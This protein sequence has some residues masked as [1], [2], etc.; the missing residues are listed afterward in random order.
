[1]L[2]GGKGNSWVSFFL[3]AP[4][5]TY[6]AGNYSLTIYDG[7]KCNGNSQTSNA[8]WGNFSTSLGNSIDSWKVCP[9]GKNP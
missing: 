2:Q 5:R 4:V 3:A 7:D 6:A 8:L 1:M 9:P